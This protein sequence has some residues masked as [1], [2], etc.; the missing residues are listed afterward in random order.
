M[1]SSTSRPKKRKLP[2]TLSEAES[3]VQTTT[4]YKSIVKQSH[5]DLL[6][7]QIAGLEGVPGQK[8]LNPDETTLWLIARYVGC[9]TTSTCRMLYI[10]L[11]H[12]SDNLTVLCQ[13]YSYT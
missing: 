7:V 10:W 13:A 3:I 2:A 11:L 5:K 1:A 6:S 9:C 8:Y 4:S 12:G